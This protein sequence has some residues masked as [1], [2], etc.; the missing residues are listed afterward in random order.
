VVKIRY[1]RD[2]NGYTHF[3]LLEITYDGPCYCVGLLSARTDGHSLDFNNQVHQAGFKW[4]FGVTPSALRAM[5]ANVAK[6]NGRKNVSR[7]DAGSGVI[8]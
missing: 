1:N 5:A 4:C 2:A 3:E 7:T 8:V 6:M